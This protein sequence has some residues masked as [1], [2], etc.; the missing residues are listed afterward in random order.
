MKKELFVKSINQIK[1]GRE[2]DDKFCKVLEEMSPETPCYITLYN[3]TETYIYE[4]F[5]R[6]LE[7]INSWWL[8]YVFYLRIRFW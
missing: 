2:F 8:Y 3:D 7:W 6:L 1:K 4:I 5:R